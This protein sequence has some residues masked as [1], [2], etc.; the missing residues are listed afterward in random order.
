MRIFNQLGGKHFCVLSLAML[1][2]SC[3]QSPEQVEPSI[4]EEDVASER[5]IIRPLEFRHRY[6]G[7]QL[8]GGLIPVIEAKN[9]A[10]GRRF[11]L[12]DRAGEEAADRK[13]D[14]VVAKFTRFQLSAA[15]RAEV[16]VGKRARQV[17]EGRPVVGPDVIEAL[18]VSDSVEVQLRFEEPLRMDI[19]KEIARKVALGEISSWEEHY[20]VNDQLKALDRAEIAAVLDPLIADARSRGVEI[21]YQCQAMYCAIAQVDRDK[22]RELAEVSGIKKIDLLGM[23]Q[24]NWTDGIHVFQG[25]QYEQFLPENGGSTTAGGEQVHD[26]ENWPATRDQVDMRVALIDWGFPEVDHPGFKE[27]TGAS[28]RIEYHYDCTTDPCSS[29]T[30]PSEAQEADHATQMLGTAIGDVRDEQDVAPNVPDGLGPEQ[31]RSGYSGESKAWVYRAGGSQ[32]AAVRAGDHL[33][34]ASGSTVPWIV[35][36]P[37]GSTTGDTNCSGDHAIDESANDLFE[38][39]RTFVFASGNNGGSSTDCVVEQPG[40]AIGTLTVGAT[41]S[42]S[43]NSTSDVRRASIYAF[44]DWGGNAIEGDNRSIIDLTP[45]GCRQFLFDINWGY[46]SAA[47]S[48]SQSSAAITG[49]LLN[50]VDW[51]I[52]R[53]S[54]TDIRN[55]PGMIH[56]NALLMGDRRNGNNSYMDTRYHHRYGAGQPEFR[57]FEAPFMDGPWGFGSGDVCV[58]DNEVVVIPINGGGTLSS[59]VDDIKVVAWWYDKRHEDSVAIDDIDLALYTTGGTSLSHSSDSD[60]EKERVYYSSAGGKALEIRLTGFDVTADNV[61]GCGTNSMNVYYAYFYEDDA[62]NDVD[63]AGADIETEGQW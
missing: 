31:Q 18:N 25:M 34:A 2:C 12:L 37:L 38:D 42:S 43:D 28:D 58:D 62:R 17:K 4:P 24:S 51:Y 16:S 26:G 27:G 14:S 60:D 57:R 29:V 11:A 19:R 30:N 61:S 49:G 39:G 7:V 48:T 52:N 6:A 1:C 3:Q 53:G 8:E 36:Q 44:S 32:A 40:S 54:W 21:T 35:H 22:L 50:Y 56:A 33:I 47:C 13:S 10:D 9:S 55:E 63:G 41:G 20:S 5:T 46:G 15:E 45:Y 23:N 59:A